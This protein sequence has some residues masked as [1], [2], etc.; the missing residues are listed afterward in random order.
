MDELIAWNQYGLQL[1]LFEIPVDP[2]NSGPWPVTQIF[3]WTGST[4]KYRGAEAADINLDGKIDFMGGGG[5][6]E[7]TGGINFTF[8]PIDGAMGYSQIKAG[9]S[10][11]TA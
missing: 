2:K 10:T 3:S 8:H 11:T 1:L 5:W 4:L 9:Q 7:N 6:F